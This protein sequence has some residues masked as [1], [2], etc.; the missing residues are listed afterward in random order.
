[1][2]KGK[3]PVSE[4]MREA[5]RILEAMLSDAPREVEDL[6]DQIADALRRGKD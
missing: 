4:G 3:E 6:A 2:Q 5:I 1:M